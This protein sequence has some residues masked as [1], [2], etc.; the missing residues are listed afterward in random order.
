MVITAILALSLVTK[1]KQRNNDEGL[2]HQHLEGTQDFS[3]TI[4]TNFDSQQ[5]TVL[6]T[7]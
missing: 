1:V 4:P 3:I 5:H 6:I 7:M 2:W